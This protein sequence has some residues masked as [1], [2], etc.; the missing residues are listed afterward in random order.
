MDE[1]NPD[2]NIQEAPEILKV[3]DGVLPTCQLSVSV[4]DPVLGL[5]YQVQLSGS[6]WDHHIAANLFR[7]AFDHLPTS[8][9]LIRKQAEKKE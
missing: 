5:T 6:H 8:L 2:I 7:Y 4:R 9:E 3:P 1:E